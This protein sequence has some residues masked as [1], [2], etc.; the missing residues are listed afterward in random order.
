VECHMPKA[1]KSAIR[2]ASYVGDVRTHIFKINTDPKAN[3][4]KTVEEKGKKSTFA[5]GFVTLDFACFSCHGSRD[6]EWASKAGK[7]FHK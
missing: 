2:V 7:G 6:R 4:F 1:S 5:K 3:M